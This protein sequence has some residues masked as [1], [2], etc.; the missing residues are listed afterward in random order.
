MIWALSC[1]LVVDAPPRKMP[2]NCKGPLLALLQIMATRVSI[3][4]LPA[5]LR[6]RRGSDFQTRKPLRA[7]AASTCWVKAAWI[8]VSSQSHMQAML[9]RSLE[10]AP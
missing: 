3:I 2:C 6:R 5:F 1:A 8:A 9:L 10:T 7:K 4:V